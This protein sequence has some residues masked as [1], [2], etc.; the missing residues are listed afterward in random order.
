MAPN[1][2]WIP[3]ASGLLGGLTTGLLGLVGIVIVTR[4]N[5]ANDK[6]RWQREMRIEAYSD[7]TATSQK[8]LMNKTGNDNEVQG[9]FYAAYFKTC[10][11]ASDDVIQAANEVFKYTTPGQGRNPTTRAEDAARAISNFM[12]YAR[13]ELGTTTRPLT[14]STN[15]PPTVH[16]AGGG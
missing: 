9:A 7:L 12:K 2:W 14:I 5:R 10:M 16:P 13:A 15:P 8:M 1:T 6:E 4:S 3:L 11:L